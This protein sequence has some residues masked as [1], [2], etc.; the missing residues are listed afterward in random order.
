M[1]DCSS[2]MCFVLILTVCLTEI[3]RE[4]PDPNIKA[5]YRLTKVLFRLTGMVHT[6]SRPV[7]DVMP[8]FQGILTF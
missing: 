4:M 7:S 5:D 2:I 3:D 8:V 1:V 6:L